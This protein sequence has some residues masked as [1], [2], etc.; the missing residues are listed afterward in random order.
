MRSHCSWP[1]IK[2]MASVTALIIEGQAIT[3]PTRPATRARF[4]QLTCSVPRKAE[5]ASRRRCNSCMANQRRRWIKRSP[6][7][8]PSRL[9]IRT[10][11]IDEHAIEESVRA[12]FR[13]L[14]CEEEPLPV[15]D[16]QLVLQQ[17]LRAR[18][19]RD[20]SCSALAPPT[21]RAGGALSCGG[22]AKHRCSI[23]PQHGIRRP[24]EPD[25][26]PACVDRCDATM[27]PRSPSP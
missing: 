5:A 18:H 25:V 12:A 20:D 24:I 23:A 2:S 15:A 26:A 3:V 1:A 27:H 4:A 19:R 13:A 17:V 21:T 9:S 6:D 8:G 11:P 7:Q 16:A 22:A 10:V 14:V